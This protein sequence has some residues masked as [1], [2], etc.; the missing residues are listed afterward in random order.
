MEPQYRQP[1]TPDWAAHLGFPYLGLTQPSLTLQAG[2]LLPP[3]RATRPLPRL[4]GRA[5]GESQLACRLLP[6]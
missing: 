2:T 3:Q 6:A 4:P 1:G 5:V